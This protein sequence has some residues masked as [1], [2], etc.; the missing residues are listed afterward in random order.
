MS[1]RIPTEPPLS[2]L[3]K[4]TATSAS[5]RPRN[6]VAQWWG[7]LA[8]QTRAIIFAGVAVVIATVIF[9]GFFT[10]VPH[11]GGGIYVVNKYTGGVTY[12]ATKLCVDAGPPKQ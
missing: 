4:A 2:S 8:D 7:N 12:C 11:A 1:P 6:R 3:P 10:V 9:S 5:G